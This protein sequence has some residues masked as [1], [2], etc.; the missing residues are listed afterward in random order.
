MGATFLKTGAGQAV[1]GL[2]LD[3]VCFYTRTECFYTRTECYTLAQSGRIG[4][5]PEEAEAG[6]GRAAILRAGGGR[7]GAVDSGMSLAAWLMEGA[8]GGV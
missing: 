6:A 2:G 8:L 5:A 3:I 7:N 4:G 1:S